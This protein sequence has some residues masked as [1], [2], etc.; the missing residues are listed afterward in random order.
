MRNMQHLW[1]PIPIIELYGSDGEGSDVT[2]PQAGAES[3][4]GSSGEASD[5][6][7]GEETFS[8]EYVKK[9]RDEAAKH[10][11][12][13]KATSDERDALQK[14]LSGIEKAEMSD[15]EG[16]K[17]DLETATTDLEKVTARATTAESA[18]KTERIRNAV[19]LAAIDAGFED[20]SDALS[21][22]SQDDIVDDEGNV[23][24][25]T[26]KAKLKALADKKPYLLKK[27]RPGSGD[28]AGSGK[29]ADPKTFEAKQAAYLEQMKAGGRV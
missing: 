8:L 19:T 22:I 1:R 7:T 21:M 10:R 23:L 9:L 6:G 17:K 27:H 28:G 5:G 16:A 4:E 12:S 18:L 24:S 29:P 25:K 14:K 13:G 11:V 2:E 3:D 15:L 20:P 26:V